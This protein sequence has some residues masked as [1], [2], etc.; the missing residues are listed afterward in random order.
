MAKGTGW[1]LS[2][3]LMRGDE[4]DADMELGV[5]LVDIGIDSLNSIELRDWMRRTIGVELLTVLEIVNSESLRQIGEKA[6]EKLMEK[7]E[8]L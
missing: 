6:Q 5:P 8:A 1:T 3:Y 4:Y 7:M 2:H